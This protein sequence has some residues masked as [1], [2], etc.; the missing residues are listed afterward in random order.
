VVDL[1]APRAADRGLELT[2]HWSHDAPGTITSDPL[3][4]RQVLSN[5]VGN[6]LKFTGEGCIVV[7]ASRD[8]EG[9]LRVEVSDTG[10]GIAAD[11]HALIFEAFTQA[12]GSITRDYG[13]TGLGLTISRRIV[14]ALGGRIGVESVP[15]AGSTFWFTLPAPA[16]EDPPAPLPVSLHGHRVVL[17]SDHPPRVA[18]LAE[19]LAVLGAKVGIATT[20]AGA[21]AAL[22]GR[23]PAVLLFD[24]AIVDR[25]GAGWLARWQAA[26]PDAR[27]VTLCPVDLL[28][29][30]DRSQF[31]A[32]LTLPITRIGTLA[33]ALS[34][35]LETR[36]G[37]LL[38]V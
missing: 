4:V 34:Q 10:I 29:R 8:L 27:L 18:A 13:G 31:A 9:A 15:G 21:G 35:A 33:D 25:E 6:A 14:E 36:G 19:D 16:T 5:L 20:P 28:A 37:S 7:R 32:V 17:L 24:Y 23:E 30:I 3:R 12:D 38:M 11:K 26:N 22:V 2:L 1:M